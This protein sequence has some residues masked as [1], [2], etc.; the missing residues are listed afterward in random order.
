MKLKYKNWINQKFPTAESALNQ[1]KEACIEM[2]KQFPELILTNGLIQVGIE[3]DM[4]NHWWLRDSNDKIIDPTAH[5]YNLFNLNIVFYSEID[6]NHDLRNFTQGRC[7]NC[8]ERYFIGKN[9][10]N[11]ST[12]C[13]NEC[14]S[15]FAK[16]LK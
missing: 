9:N 7:C 14:Y 11:N 1:C 4:R 16:S 6:D 2:K 3:K 5:Q 15:L 10:W 12:V 8:G 13:S